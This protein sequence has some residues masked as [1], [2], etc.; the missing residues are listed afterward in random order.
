MRLFLLALF[1]G[2][3]LA[4]E[5]KETPKAPPPPPEVIL[6]RLWANRAPHD[7]ALQARLFVE[8]DRF[9][10][11]EVRI[12][13]LPDETRTI[14][15]SEKTELLVVQS[16]RRPARFYLAG[17]GE[18]ATPQQ[19][20]EKLLGSWI[21]Y[22]DLGLP[23]L[24]WPN[25]KYLG[26]DRMRGQDCHLLE[27]KSDTAPY[28]RVKLWIHNEYFALLKAEAFDADENPVKRITVTSFKRIGNV[29]IPRGMDFSFIPPGQ[30]L[31]SSERSRLEIYEG[32]YDARLPLSEF[33]PTRF[34]ANP[35]APNN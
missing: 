1:S 9:V 20:M 13:N 22:Y 8:R 2:S 4:L 23:F 17:R 35:K 25:L 27:V 31:P 5:E 18:L 21:S 29:W 7:L 15:R 33:D 24:S 6:Q 26:E 16:P 3:V 10:P 12:K 30:S 28:R 32:N 14:Y 19:Q 11:I 34:G